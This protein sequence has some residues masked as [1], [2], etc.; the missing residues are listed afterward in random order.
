MGISNRAM[1]ILPSTIVMALRRSTAIAS[2]DMFHATPSALG[3]QPRLE[4]LAAFCVATGDTGKEHAFL[5][6]LSDDV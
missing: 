4:G 3:R 2:A 6:G 1:T 5:C